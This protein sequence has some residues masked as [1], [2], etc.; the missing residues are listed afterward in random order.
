METSITFKVVDDEGHPVEGALVNPDFYLTESR[1]D[2][3]LT[4]ENG[5]ATVKGDGRIGF[6][7]KVTKSGYYES[8]G[9]PSLNDNALGV[10][11]REI[12][13]PI[14]MYG[15][16]FFFPMTGEG[17]Y[18]L[19]YDFMAGDFLPPFGEGIY[20]DLEIDSKIV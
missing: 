20:S 8:V 2:S 3:V 10:V 12:R 4:D 16:R 18:T 7:F 14:A 5:N 13:N 15:K 17:D 1:R 6:G 9:N 19:Y 11:L